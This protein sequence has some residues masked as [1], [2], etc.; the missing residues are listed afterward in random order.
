MRGG[1]CVP[2][3][4]GPGAAGPGPAARETTLFLPLSACPSAATAQARAPAEDYSFLRGLR[5]VAN[6]LLPFFP[7]KIVDFFAINMQEGM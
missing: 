2:H 1:G 6:P 5:P 4:L 7:F 3:A